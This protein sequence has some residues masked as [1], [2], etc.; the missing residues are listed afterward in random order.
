MA[1]INHLH[2]ETRVFKVGPHLEMLCSQ[3][4]ANVSHEVVTTPQDPQQMKETLYCRNISFV[5]KHLSDGVFPPAK[6]KQVI[7]AI[8]SAAV[9]KAVCDSCPNELLEAWPSMQV[10]HS[11]A[12]SPCITR[13]MLSQIHS[14]K[15]FHLRS[16]LKRIGRTNDDSCPKCCVSPHTAAHLFVCPAHVT[17]L[18]R[19]DC[20]KR[21]HEVAEFLTTLPSFA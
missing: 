15:C 13:C 5:A 12:T 17:N 7:N 18:V 6:Y 19:I 8:H 2:S 20:W 3:F 10:D 14:T 16:Y 4:L 21:V 9:A 1:S 11:E